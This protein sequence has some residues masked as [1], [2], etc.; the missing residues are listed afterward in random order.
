MARIVFDL[1]GTLI[2]SAPDIRAGAN[3]LLAEEG[4]APLSVAETRSFIGNGAAV[5][6]QRMRAARGIAGDQHDR[7]L[8]EFTRRYETFVDLTHPYPGAVAALN[9][10]AQ[11][12]HILGICTNKPLRPTRAVL[13]R[14]DLTGFFATIWGGDSLT[15]HK[16]DPAPLHA[17]F[18]ALGTGPASAAP[19]IYVGDSEV[20]AETAQRAGVPFVL[21]TEGYRKTPLDQVP[22]THAFDDFAALPGIVA[23]MLA[24]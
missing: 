3:A 20:D 9:A 19:M 4:H 10:L 11:A 1:D 17:A 15:V 8:A 16:P 21:F 13:D 12:G 14:L 7:L 22:H 5:F 18:Q 23:G 2:D 6:V 24:G